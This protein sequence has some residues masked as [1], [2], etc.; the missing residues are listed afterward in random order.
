M[1]LIGN[2]N[3]KITSVRYFF[4]DSAEQLRYFDPYERPIRRWHFGWETPL[5][6]L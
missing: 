3:K 4:I 5:E 2:V 6:W 1:A